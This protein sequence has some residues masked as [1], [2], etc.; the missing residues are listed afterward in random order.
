MKAGRK[1]KI[2]TVTV[3]LVVLFLI[4]P[5]S[6]LLLSMGVMS[7]YSGMHEKESVTL[8]SGI[9]VNIP[10]GK[11][12]YPFVMTFNPSAES[13]RSFLRNEART[14]EGLKAVTASDAG[15][16][17]D[18][19]LSIMYNFPAFDL[20]FGKGCSRL[21][22]PSSE[23]YNSFYGAYAT[24]SDGTAFGFNA[25]GEL[26]TAEIAAVAKYDFQK[27]VLGDF[28]LKASELVF[29]WS[30]TELDTEAVFMGEEAW[31]RVDA[32]L[33]VSGASHQ[34]QAF[35]Q[36]YLQ[37]GT[38]KYDLNKKEKPFIPVE[39]KGRIYAKYL[40]EQDISLFFYIVASQK[41]LLESCDRDIL[42]HSMVRETS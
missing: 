31:Q 19:R 22:D 30:E 28:G 5:F 4:S 40:P 16:Y 11:G 18:L 8:N 33:I 21:Y 3:L 17:D 41:E 36:S 34:K 38:P 32:D 10:S 14:D 42:Q 39:M 1:A 35:V 12:W 13:F 23:Y 6:K 26:N 9:E 25:D 24:A 29:E 2:V 20:G 7:V 27:L 15:R 37:Y